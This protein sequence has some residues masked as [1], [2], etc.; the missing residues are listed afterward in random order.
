MSE[1]FLHINEKNKMATIYPVQIQKFCQTYDQFQP[2]K[3]LN[4][5][6]SYVSHLEIRIKD[7]NYWELLEFVLHTNCNLPLYK[8]S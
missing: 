5:F 2:Q 8:E 6:Y 7:C 4:L 3:I 1:C